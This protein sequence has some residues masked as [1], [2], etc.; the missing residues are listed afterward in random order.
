MSAQ[1]GSVKGVTTKK[2]AAAGTCY[3]SQVSKQVNTKTNKQTTTTNK[4]KRK[5]EKDVQGRYE[6]KS[7]GTATQ[8]F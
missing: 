8:H 2:E 4:R 6:S 5:K 1:K 7:A 3:I